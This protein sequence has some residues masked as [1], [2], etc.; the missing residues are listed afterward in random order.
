MSLENSEFSIIRELFA[1]LTQDNSGAYLL[2]DDVATI[3]IANPVITKDLM[4]A[5][6]HFRPNDPMDLVARKLMRVNISDLVAKGVRPA[7]YF[8]GCAWPVIA[9]RKMIRAFVRGLGEDQEIYKC[10]LMG[11]DTTRQ[12]LKSAPLMLSATFFGE[13]PDVGI[14]RRSGASVGDDLYVTGTIGDAGLGL[15]SL[16]G[17]I[18]PSADDRD[19][20]QSRYWLPEPRVTFGTALGSFASAALDVSD[21]LIADCTHMASQS[22]VGISI[23][24]N[25]M[26][27]SQAATNWIQEQKDEQKALVFL[28]TCGDDYEVLFTAPSSMRRSVQVAAKAS[29]TSVSRIGSVTRDEGVRVLHDSDEVKIATRGYDHFTD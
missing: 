24:L 21:G 3:D 20:L 14:M 17:K 8:L 16:E 23:S 28:A 13:Q 27:L 7:G 4:I 2:A 6:V 12:K 9:D 5:G 15:R 29:R 19:F 26:P 25:D 18:K 11:G 10:F 1:P 22:S